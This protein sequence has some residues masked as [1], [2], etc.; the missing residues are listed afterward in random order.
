M[1]AKAAA[2]ELKPQAMGVNCVSPAAVVTPMWQKM[3]FW[4][5]LVQR[6]GREL[7]AWKELGGIDPATPS[8]QRMALP[9][10]VASA[11]VFLS[12][13]ESAHITGEE[14]VVDGGYTL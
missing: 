2:L 11:I 8:I 6:Q 12:C 14:L 9:E 13:D 10:E 5:D 3:P 7:G 4:R 1:L